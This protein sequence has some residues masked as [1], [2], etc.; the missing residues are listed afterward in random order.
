MKNFLFLL[1]VCLFCA[2]GAFGQSGLV[3]GVLN[4]QAQMF[5]M[6]EHPQHASQ[7]GMAEEQNILE[8]SNSTWGHGERPLWELMPEP[9]FVSLGDVA[10]SYRQEHASAKK[11][12]KVWKN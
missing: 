1:V 12:S 11:A 7:T 10:R 3:G 5:T 9:P 8:H 2:S 4:T 6:P